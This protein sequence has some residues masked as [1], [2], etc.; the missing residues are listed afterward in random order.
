MGDHQYRATCSWEGSTAVGYHAYD[1]TH[2]V[3]APPAVGELELSADPTFLGD[4]DRYNPESLVVMAAASCQLLSFLA[5]AARARV[6][7]VAYD[8]DATGAMS[9]GGTSICEIRLRPHITVREPA[10]EARVADLVDA[11]HRDCYVANSLR[12]EVVVTPVVT[13]VPAARD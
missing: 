8:D 1:R 5:V 2:R 7:V 4:P 11:A 3:T 12:S 9:R 13:V 6:D 10:T